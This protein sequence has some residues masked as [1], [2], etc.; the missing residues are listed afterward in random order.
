MKRFAILFVVI[1]STI[2]TLIVNATPASPAI[3]T[4]TPARILLAG[5]SLFIIQLAHQM[6]NE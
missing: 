5:S 3:T 1:L 4:L 6:N 2:A